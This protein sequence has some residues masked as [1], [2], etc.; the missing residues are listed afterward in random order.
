MEDHVWFRH[1]LLR[2][3]LTRD[4]GTAKAGSVHAAYAATLVGLDDGSAQDAADIAVHWEH[5]ERPSEAF[6]WTLVAAERAAASAPPPRGGGRWTGPVG[7]GRAATRMT[8]SRATS[9]S[10]AAPPRPLGW[11]VSSPSVGRLG[12]AIELVHRDRDPL[13]ATA[14]LSPGW[15]AAG[16]PPPACR[17][18]VR[19]ARGRRAGRA[20][21]RQPGA[22]PAVTELAIGFVWDLMPEPTD[23]LEP[24]DPPVPGRPTARLAVQ[25]AQDRGSPRALAR[26]LCALAIAEL[27]VPGS[28][29]LERLQQAYDLAVIA[30]D[31]LTMGFAAIYWQ[32]EL[33]QEG[34]YEEQVD[35][36]A[37]FAREL[38]EA[39]HTVHS[40]LLLAC[41]GATLVTLGHWAQGEALLRPG[42]A[43]GM[44][45][46]GGISSSAAAVL[47][48]RRGRAS[49]A[50]GFWTG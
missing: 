45:G 1:P 42:L 44:R 15:G 20:G 3:V 17:S 14:F 21:A 37:R 5:A 18:C 23:D 4:S 30:G 22:A 19:T 47:S 25:L 33:I 31:P 29:S 38:G 46:I 12:E 27:D 35:L 28:G 7:C 16:T 24:G 43:L 8:T 6:A 10:F 13:L 41:G 26:A 11:Q 39:G 32:H 34:R 50:N 2:D 9:I 40:H 36:A 49:T 48:V